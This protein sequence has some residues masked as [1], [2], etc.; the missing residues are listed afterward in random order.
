MTFIMFQL[1]GGDETLQQSFRTIGQAL[2][3][4]FQNAKALPARQASPAAIE[5]KEFEGEVVEEEIEPEGG[6]GSEEKP[7]AS[8]QPGKK[9]IYRTVPDLNLQPEGSEPLRDFFKGK[10]PESQQ[11][12]FA[13]ILFY[14]THKLKI[15][16]VGVNHI[17]TAFSNV[18]E[19]VPNI[20]SSAGNIARRRDWINSPP[21]M[22]NLTLTMNGENFVTHDLP[23]AGVAA[24]SGDEE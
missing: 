15:A 7:K 4:A 11:E 1:D 22:N 23:R 14:L 2:G 16:G 20:R 18:N 21:D 17:Y 9:P 10:K 5:E 6:N 12:Q 3:N 24:S 19:P 13:V 8:R